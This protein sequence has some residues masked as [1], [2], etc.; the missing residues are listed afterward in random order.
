MRIFKSWKTQ[1]EI[2]YDSFCKGLYSMSMSV[3]SMLSLCKKQQKKH[4]KIMTDKIILEM[5]EKIL[6][7]EK[8]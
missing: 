5:I 2:E 7:F 1:S 4:P 3:K 8:S 6:V